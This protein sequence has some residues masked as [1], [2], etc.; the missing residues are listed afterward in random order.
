MNLIWYSTRSIAL[1]HVIYLMECTLCK[2]QYVGKLESNFI[3]DN[4]KDVKRPKRR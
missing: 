3:E 1:L 2:N 4:R